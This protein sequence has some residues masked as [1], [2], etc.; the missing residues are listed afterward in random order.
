MINLKDIIIESLLDDEDVILKKQDEHIKTIIKQFLEDN[1]NGASSCKISRKPNK[2]GK[3]IVD[4]KT[5]YV[6]NKSITSLTNGYFE[7]G[8]INGNFECLNCKSLTSLEGAPEKVRGYF[9]CS[10]CNRLTSLEGAPEK[11][12]E[13]F[14][15]NNCPSL[16]SLKGAPREVND[17]FCCQGC[18]SLIS[19]E[20]APRE[21][22]GDFYCLHC[23]SLTSLKGM[24]EKLGMDF[25]CKYCNSLT[26]LEDVPNHLKGK[27]IK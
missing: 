10:N 13:S 4:C 15:C 5:L 12:G 24:P 6:R 2:N 26:S 18:D 23:N 14:Y 7:F 17:D 22:G 8:T 1:Y 20:G 27:I 3:Y 11:V 19:L 16:T 21:V 9:D 25:Y